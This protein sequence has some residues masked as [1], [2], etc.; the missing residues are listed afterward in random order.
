[1]VLRGQNVELID[2]KILQIDDSKAILI[3][4]FP[5]ELHGGFEILPGRSCD[6]KCRKNLY[7]YQYLHFNPSTFSL[8]HFLSS[9]FSLFF[10]LLS[11]FIF[12]SFLFIPF[13]LYFS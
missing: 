12:Y 10:F 6:V 3:V 2:E 8:F 11:H 4:E 7:H 13:Y 1:M 9:I 5:H